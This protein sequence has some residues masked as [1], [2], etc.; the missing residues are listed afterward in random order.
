MTFNGPELAP[1]IFTPDELRKILAVCPANLMPHIVIGAFSGIRAAEIER[2]DW[3][4]VLWDRGYIEI[5]AAKAKTKARRL[6][7]LLPNLRAWLEP[8]RKAEGPVCCLPNIA[9]RLI[10]YF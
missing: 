5:K 1:A 6:V 7:P 8:A 2:L 3:K 9:F 4:D 10:P